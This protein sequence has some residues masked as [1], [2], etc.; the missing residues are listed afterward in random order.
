MLKKKSKEARAEAEK[1][2]V[3]AKRLEAVENKLARVVGTLTF[4]HHQRYQK[5]QPNIASPPRY[6][7][8][9]RFTRNVYQAMGG[10]LCR[11]Y[12]MLI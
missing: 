12:Q 7:P 2:F 9:A 3:D 6:S 1:V 5:S 4:L 8:C 11:V 10:R